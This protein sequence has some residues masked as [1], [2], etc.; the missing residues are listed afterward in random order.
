MQASVV[1]LSDLIAIGSRRWRA[2]VDDTGDDDAGRIGLVY[3]D[4]NY[5]RQGVATLLLQIAEAESPR[6]GW[7]APRHAD[8]RAPDGEARRGRLAEVR[9]RVR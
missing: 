3:V 6:R 4:P 7:T 2:R 9:R 1:I 8:E 5:R